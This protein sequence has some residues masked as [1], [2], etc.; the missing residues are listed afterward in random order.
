MCIRVSDVL[1]LF[2]ARRH[3]EMIEGLRMESAQIPSKKATRS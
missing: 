2:A 1:Q 3:F